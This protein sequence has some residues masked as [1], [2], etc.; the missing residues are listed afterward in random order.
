M[1]RLAQALAS[2]EVEDRFVRRGAVAPHQRAASRQ[3]MSVRDVEQSLVARLESRVKDHADIHHD[4]YEERRGFDE[5]AQILTLLHKTHGHGLAGLNQQGL[6]ALL[7]AAQTEP[8]QMRRKEEKTEVVNGPVVLPFFKRRGEG[9]GLVEPCAVAG[10][11]GENEHQTRVE[12][13]APVRPAFAVV[14]EFTRDGVHRVIIG[15]IFSQQ[16]LRLTLRE[17]KRAL[18]SGAERF[19]PRRRIRHLSFPPYAV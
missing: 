8:S 14:A 4:V 15:G 13:V 6:D 16:R 1:R 3:T 9:D 18:Q 19:P 2:L 5:R 12:P 11:F 10:G 17:I 7:R